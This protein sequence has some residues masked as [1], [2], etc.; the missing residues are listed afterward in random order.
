ML[1]LSEH[2]VESNFQDPSIVLDTQR[3]NRRELYP[4]GKKGQTDRPKTDRQT[5]TAESLSGSGRSCL[6][7]QTDTRLS[8]PARSQTHASYLVNGAEV[9]QTQQ[10][11]MQA[12]RGLQRTQPR[13][14]EHATLPAQAWCSGPDSTRP[15]QTLNL[16]PKLHHA[17]L[18]K[19]ANQS[20]EQAR[21]GS[22]A[23][24][25]GWQNNTCCMA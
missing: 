21:S 5:G 18:S 17:I 10:P 7:G 11:S 4:G 25:T 8:I 13:R 20:L 14:L 1:S 16:T 24:D 15:L 12:S 23:A 9:V 2:Q 6:Q 3:G 22:V 19:K